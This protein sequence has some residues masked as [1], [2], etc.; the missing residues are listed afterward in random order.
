MALKIEIYEAEWNALQD[1][2]D[3]VESREALLA[4]ALR[5]LMFQLKQHDPG[6]CIEG[7]EING[8]NV[9]RLREVRE[10]LKNRTET[11]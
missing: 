10:A 9:D 4:K 7:R 2:L 11:P 6:G 5:G 1:R 8:K 3:K